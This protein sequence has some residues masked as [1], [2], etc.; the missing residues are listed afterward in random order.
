M[1]TNTFA[2]LAPLS[3]KALKKQRKAT[4]ATT[5]I[6]S[7]RSTATALTSTEVAPEEEDIH[8][9][10]TAAAVT[11]LLAEG[12][13]TRLPANHSAFIPPEEDEEDYYSDFA[14]AAAAFYAASDPHIALRWVWDIAFLHG[15]REGQ[16]EA[17]KLVS[18]LEAAG[19]LPRVQAKNEDSIERV[20]IA[21]GTDLKWTR[22]EIEVAEGNARKIGRRETLERGDIM[23]KDL[24]VAWR[25]K[26]HVDEGECMAGRHSRTHIAIGTEE[27]DAGAR[28]ATQHA[29]DTAGRKELAR[30]IRHGHTMDGEC[31]AGRQRRIDACV[32]VDM[33]A[34]EIRTRSEDTKKDEESVQEERVDISVGTDEDTVQAQTAC[35]GMQTMVLSDFDVMASGPRILWDDDVEE[36]INA[37]LIPIHSVTVSTPPAPVPRDFSD[38]KSGISR[39]FSSLHRRQKRSRP[40]DRHIQPAPN[41]YT[42]CTYTPNTP[43]R[44]F[45]PPTHRPV[46]YPPVPRPQVQFA[47][48]RQPEVLDWDRDPRLRKLSSVLKELGW[49]RGGQFS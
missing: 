43:R 40:N 16:V 47:R 46:R 26:G 27:M 6:L 2:P 19:K 36:S 35:V 10:T 21:V 32:A 30:W 23:M 17:E 29:A 45:R 34:D 48:A 18:R 38:L 8:H 7:S 9:F 1:S 42:K 33:Q 15:K 14:N 3:K 41:T 13:T 22:S 11:S 49:T 25:A 44:P 24:R 4:A 5:A 37:G 20:S 39:P 31:G 12:P 28:D